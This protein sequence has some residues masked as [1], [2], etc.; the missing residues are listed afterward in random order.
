[1]KDALLLM[2]L[3]MMQDVRQNIKDLPSFSFFIIIRGRHFH[4]CRVLISQYKRFRGIDISKSQ[5][6]GIMGICELL[7]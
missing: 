5:R 4:S 2:L 1:M 3:L 6:L 7:M